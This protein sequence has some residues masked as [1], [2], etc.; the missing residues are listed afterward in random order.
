[1]SLR[2][3]RCSEPGIFYNR[4]TTMNR[5]DFFQKSCLTGLGVIAGLSILDTLEIATIKASPLPGAL[6]SVREVPLM[7]ID[8]PELQ[9]IGGAYHLDIEEL[10]KNILVVRTGEKTFNAVDLKCT[11]KGCEV[12]YD[13]K[14]GGMYNCP[15]HGSTF[16]IKG[17]ATKGPAKKPLQWYETVLKDGEV[18][19]KI[20]TAG[21]APV[22]IKDTTIVKFDT[23]KK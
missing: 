9:V 13:A 14:D 23:I 12:A 2:F 5:R 18:T 22:L 19:V 1:M 16:S 17:E 8:V 4:L 20:P 3:G 10:D 11:H 7:L 15:C 6:G 21:D